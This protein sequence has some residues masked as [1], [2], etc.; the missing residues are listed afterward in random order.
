MKYIEANSGIKILVDDE[1]HPYLSR[2]TWVVCAN[3]TGSYNVGMNVPSEKGH[4]MGTGARIPMWRFLLAP[5]IQH[6]AIFINRN[7]LDHRK[8][9]IA[10]VPPSVFN[11][12]AGVRVNNGKRG[13]KTSRHKGV[14][15]IK[16]HTSKNWMMS[17]QIDGKSIQE[18]YNT[19]DDAGAR[20][21]KLA[22][23]A[24]GE[25]AYLNTGLDG[26]IL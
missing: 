7:P 25:Y 9:N 18:H 12:H 6:K 11:A 15:Y 2:F 1:D 26:S 10:L 22:R 16:A 20:Y 21:N 4:S 14:S 13:E 3:K 24:W 8:E 19:E 17:I 5:K 23:G